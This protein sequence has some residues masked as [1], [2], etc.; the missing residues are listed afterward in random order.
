MKIAD[1][2]DTVRHEL[3]KFEPFF[4]QQLQSPIPLLSAITNHIY[5]SKG[6]ELRPLLVFLSA[7][8]N[9]KICQKT[10]AGAALVELVHTA[11]LMHDDVVDNADERRST[12]SVKALWNSQKAVL[13]GD[14]L[15]GRSVLLALEHQSVEFLHISSNTIRCM[16]EGELQQLERAR[17]LEWSEEQYFD[18]I[19]R[20]TAALIQ[21]CT[22]IGAH[23]A[24]AT[25]ERLAAVGRY[26][27]LLG[28]AFQLRDDVLDFHSSSVTGKVCG[29]DIREKKITLPLIFALNKAD[30]AEQKKILS[31]V[32]T[33]SVNSRNVKQVVNFVAAH[34]G[35]EYTEG[36]AHGYCADAKRALDIF[37]ASDAK[38]ALLNLADVVVER[39]K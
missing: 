31:L 33:A 21:N 11:T 6:K 20:K 26:G 4:R 13:A 14:F 10:Y 23:S 30:K 12:L 18:I 22:L 8:L 9:G 2:Q 38:T 32:A 25:G 36:V 34:G 29:N 37:P 24:G 19:R 28:I 35:L 7:K 17:K 5:R 3:E 16:S 39:K 15:L 1:I 27:E